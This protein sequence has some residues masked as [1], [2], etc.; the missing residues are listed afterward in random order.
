MSEKVEMVLCL[1]SAAAAEVIGTKRLDFI[2]Y[3]QLSNSS[4]EE[5]LTTERREKWIQAISR[6]DT[7]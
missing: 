7:I 6:G 3:H 2:E 5:E 1:V 4:F